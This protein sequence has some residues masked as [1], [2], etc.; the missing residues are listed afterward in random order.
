[1]KENKGITLIALVITIIVLLILAGVAIATLTGENGVLTQAENA[2]TQTEIAEVIERAK[3]DIVA[4]QT[5]KEGKG[6]DY[7]LTDSIVKSILM[8]KN[9]VE[10][11]PGETS[12]VSTNGHTIS[13]ADLYD[14][15]STITEVM[16]AESGFDKN[17]T[18]VDDYGNTVKVP[19]GF[20]IA[21]DSATNVTGGVVIEDAT[22]GATAGSQFV[23]IPVGKVYTNKE[24]TDYESINLSRYTF[25]SLGNETD[26]GDEIIV[27]SI[28]DN[29]MELDISDKGNRTALD[30]EEFKRKANSSHGYYIGRYESRTIRLRD[31]ATANSELTQITVKPNDYVYVSVTQIQAAMLSQNM[32]TSDNFKSDLMNSYAWDTAVVFLQKFDDRNNKTNPYSQKTSSISG[33]LAE[34]GTNNMEEKYQDEICNIWDVGSNSAEY[35]TETSSAENSPCVYRGGYFGTNKVTVSSR[36]SLKIDKANMDNGFRTLLY[37]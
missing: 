17:T 10:G 7:T 20:K 5:E 12:F 27:N 28:G 22:D 31:T 6:E 19:E 2:G 34:K 18:V 37:L 16:G 15:I 9:Y 36:F 3:L 4:W 8:G 23:W 29:F 35:I 32:Y 26:A 14:R 33:S 30:I 13:Y 25:D 11:E 21:S 1:M 24:Q